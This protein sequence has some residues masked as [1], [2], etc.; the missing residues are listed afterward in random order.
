MSEPTLRCKACGA[1]VI[2]KDDGTLERTCGHKEAT[3]VME[4]AAHVRGVG[5][6][7]QDKHGNR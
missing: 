6:L 4:L 5:A 1:R 2:R 7:A 3:V